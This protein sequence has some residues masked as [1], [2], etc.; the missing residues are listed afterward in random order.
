[1]PS[2]VLFRLFL[3]LTTQVGSIS[4]VI[5]LIFENC[6]NYT[7]LNAKI[8]VLWAIVICNSCT[9]L[10]NVK[11][12]F[13][14]NAQP[15]S[16]QCRSR[17]WVFPTS[18]LQSKMVFVYT[19]TLLAGT[20]S[21]FL[22]FAQTRY[23]AQTCTDCASYSLKALCP[24]RGLASSS[25][26]SFCQSFHRLFLQPAESGVFSNIFVDTARFLW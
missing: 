19:K 20:N 21:Q 26:L 3:L 22:G 9:L 5:R 6:Y 11:K 18:I 13:C 23:S 4:A 17:V 12:V 16:A 24:T 8:N 25:P 7:L 2:N 10:R 15:A 14:K 1:M